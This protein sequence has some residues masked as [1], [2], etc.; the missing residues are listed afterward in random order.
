MDIDTNRRQ[1]RVNGT[2]GIARMAQPVLAATNHLLGLAALDERYQRLPVPEHFRDFLGSAL[3]ALQVTYDVPAGD[4]L[5]VP[6]DGPVVVVANH[7]FG[8]LDGL[9]IAHLLSGLRPDLRV[10]AN[11]LLGRITELDPILIPVNP[12]GGS[13][14]SATN[15]A[16]TR[17]ALRW[18]EQGGLLLTFPAGEVSHFTPVRG[19]V[20]DPPWRNSVAM[21]AR[22]ANAAVVPLFVHGR[23]SGLFQVSGLVHRRLRTALLARELLNKAGMR[24]RLRIGA[25]VAAVQRKKFGSD[26]AFTDFLRCRT[27]LLG[28]MQA[29]NV[30]PLRAGTALRGAPVRDAVPAALLREEIAHLPAERCYLRSGDLRVFITSAAEIPWTL[31]E[32][33]RLR[34][35]SFR[36]VG[37]GTGREVDL[38]RY[39][40]YYQHLFLWD[41]RTARVIGGYR[42]GIVAEIVERLGLDGL[43]LHSLFHFAKRLGKELAPAIELGRSFVRIE[44]QRSF[45]P[46]L[47]LWRGIGA[48]VARRPELP[49][50]IGPVSVSN[51][52]QPLSR[53]LMIRFLEHHRLERRMAR[54]VRP[55]NPTTP[56]R[57]FPYT[58]DDLA[59]LDLHGLD[60]LVTEIEADQRGVPVLLRQYLKLGGRILGFNVDPDFGDVIDCLLL[61]DLRE[62]EPS[63]LDRYLGA[64]GARAF[65]DH[66][67]RAPQ[68]AATG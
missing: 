14:A 2:T 28:T 40:S 65:L 9:V 37:E 38:D 53:Q 20:A 11:G 61:V 48:F 29:T 43:Y 25:P 24:V 39:D 4:L 50:L 23:N 42:L 10:L 22:R 57:A 15:L 13:E 36:A 52:Y 54:G 7:P 21:L 1:L 45:A 27:Y 12:F 33:G 59:A 41:D 62:V 60:E 19:R 6:K 30:T 51:E 55:R 63:L 44:E 5:H 66:H 49:L 56:L 8:G 32:I 26:L 16:G 31:Q 68:A 3:D 34:E 47:L 18:L 64:D 17:A 67:A 35:L 58:R 46:L